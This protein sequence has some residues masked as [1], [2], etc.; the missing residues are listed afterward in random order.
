[1]CLKNQIL[2]HAVW[3]QLRERALLI[4]EMVGAVNGRGTRPGGKSMF[5]LLKGISSVSFME[6]SPTSWVNIKRSQGNPLISYHIQGKHSAGILWSIS[7]Y[8]IAIKKVPC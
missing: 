7:S 8:S 2:H 4:S 6:L 3:E 5:A 1:M